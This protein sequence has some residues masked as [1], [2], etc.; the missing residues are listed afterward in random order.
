MVRGWCGLFYLDFDAAFPA[1]VRPGFHAQNDD[2]HQSMNS[3]CHG[4]GKAGALH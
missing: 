4:K 2:R 1:N 3:Q